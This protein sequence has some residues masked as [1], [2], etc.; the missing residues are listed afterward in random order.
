MTRL[1]TLATMLAACLA[2]NSSG[3]EPDAGPVDAAADV[4]PCEGL[5]AVAAQIGFPPICQACIGAKCCSQFQTCFA[6]DGCASI[7]TC[8]GDCIEKMGMS[9][10]SCADKCMAESDASVEGGA[11]EDGGPIIE[12]TDLNACIVGQCPVPCSNN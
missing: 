2:C 10:L 7:E 3:S 4:A 8:T 5:D 9:P 6:D 12:A 1:A 11:A